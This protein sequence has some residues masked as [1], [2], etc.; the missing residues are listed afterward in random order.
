MTVT[1]GISCV[2]PEVSKDTE[3]EVRLFDELIRLPR[4]QRN[5]LLE[6]VKLYGELEEH[7]DLLS[8]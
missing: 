4:S 2:E 3:V 5:R 6:A 7:H 8:E 1:K